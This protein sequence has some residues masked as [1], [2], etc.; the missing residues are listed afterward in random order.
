MFLIN[1]N[2]FLMI[3]VDIMVEFIF[4]YLFNLN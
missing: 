4:V 3:V 1:G 2:M